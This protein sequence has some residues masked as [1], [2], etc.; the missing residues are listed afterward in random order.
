VKL[1]PLGVVATGGDGPF[2]VIHLH[3]HFL[4]AHTSSHD[5]ASLEL[6]ETTQSLSPVD[7]SPFRTDGTGAKYLATDGER[8]FVS[9]T[10]SGTLSVFDFD[11]LSGRLELRKGQRIS[12]PGCRS[13]LARSGKLYV[14][15]ETL[16]QI[17]IFDILEDGSPSVSE[18]SPVESNGLGSPS[19]LIA[20]GKYLY[21]ANA[22]S[23]SLCAFAFTSE[24]GLEA[25]SDSPFALSKGDVVDM[26]VPGQ[27]PK[28]LIVL[29]S[30]GSSLLSLTISAAGR[31]Q[32]DKDSPIQLGGFASSVESIGSLILMP[33]A[34]GTAIKTWDFED[35]SEPVEVNSLIA[36]AELIRVAFSD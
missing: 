23:R 25:L 15:S 32:E 14:A 19:A 22:K 27:D 13:L 18:A 1:T 35:P 4:V 20:S 5:V 16:G 36:G 10:K 31:V 34:G 17:E 9:N 8:V 6:D 11:P 3:G 24:G 29:A 26:A 28:K 2:D 12:V 7:G 33:L 30:S 21:A